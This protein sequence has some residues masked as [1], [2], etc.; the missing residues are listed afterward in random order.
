MQFA[1]QFGEALT[2]ADV[3]VVSDIY[4]SRE[5]PLPGVTGRL[6]ADAAAQRG[7]QTH[8][9]PAKADL[10]AALQQLVRPGDLVMT[11]GAGDV[12]IVGPMLAKLLA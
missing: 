9:V 10:P 5:D 4:G 1:D 11:L 6:V 12:T 2:L 3:V 8:Y 7:A